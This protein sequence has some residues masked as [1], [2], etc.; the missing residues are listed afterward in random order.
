MTKTWIIFTW[1][2]THLIHLCHLTEFAINTYCTFVP[3]SRIYQKHIS[4]VHLCICPCSKR[5]CV[6]ACVAKKYKTCIFYGACMS[7]RVQLRPSDGPEERQ[8]LLQLS[9]RYFNYITYFRKIGGTY[10]GTFCAKPNTTQNKK[11]AT[12]YCIFH[13]FSV[14]G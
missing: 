12:F 8:Q 5:A 9:V 4:Y 14:F 7:V 1:T 11:G 2:K 3:L 10:L 6:R 13:V